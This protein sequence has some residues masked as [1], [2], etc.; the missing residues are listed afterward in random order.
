MLSNQTWVHLPAHS[1]ANLWTPAC[2]E[3]KYSVYIRAPNKES[4]QLVLK[5]PELHSGFQGKVFK[6]QG[7]GEGCGVCDQLMDILLIG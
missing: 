2:G 7:E 3:G 6:R 1:K 5:R 4:R